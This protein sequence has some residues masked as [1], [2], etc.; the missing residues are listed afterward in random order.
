VKLNAM[1]IGS[2]PIVFVVKVAETLPLYLIGDE[3]R[4]KQ[5]MNN[6]LS[7]AIKY[8]E[9]GSVTFE[10]DSVTDDRGIT[11]IFTVRDTGQGMTEEQLYTVYDEYSMFNR[12]VN[13]ATEGTGLGMSITKNLVEMMSGGI[14]AESKLSKGSAFTVYLMQQ[15]T[16]DDSVIGYE[17]AENLENFTFADIT[18]TD[19]IEREYIPYGSVLIVDD[20]DENLFVAKGLMKP[21]G[22]SIET[23]LSG[24]ECVDKI[25][26]GFEYDIIFMDHMMPGMDGIETTNKIREMGYTKPIV[27]LT[28]NAVVGQKESFLENGF[29]DFISKPIDIQQLN[30][31]LNQL[32]RNKM[33]VEL[34]EKARS[35]VQNKAKQTVTSDA[36][37]AADLVSLLKQIDGLNVDYALKAMSGF[38][39]VYMDTVKLTVRLLPVRIETMDSFIINDVKIFTNEVH[40]LKS[41]LRNIG[42]SALGEAAASLERAALDKDMQYCNEAYPAFRKGLVELT[43]KLNGAL[44]QH[45]ATEIKEAADIKSL[46]AIINDAKTATEGYDRDGALSIIKPHT[47][48]TYGAETDDLLYEIV[49]TLEL[50]DCEDALQKLIKLEAITNEII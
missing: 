17:I 32:I 11:L 35:E 16:D 18:H 46:I 44:L 50:F 39:D 37:Q 31:I 30:N 40:G 42:A 3:L 34:V 26:E 47:E 8:T 7:N 38:E 29:D 36:G 9:Q 15:P 1:R 45:K 19:K 13:R 25:N 14:T 5:I 28:A 48:Y 2:K 10:I 43:D 22:L 49:C 20:L 12:E 4:I 23:M 41:A 6:L 33:P 21:Y 24:Y 27:A